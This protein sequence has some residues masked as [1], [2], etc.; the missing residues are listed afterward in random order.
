VCDGCNRPLKGRA[1][2]AGVPE[3]YERSDELIERIQELQRERA[4]LAVQ[5]VEHGSINPE[6][7]LDYLSDLA[8]CGEAPATKA[9]DGGSS[10]SGGRYR[11]RNWTRT[12]DLCTSIANAGAL[13][14][15]RGNARDSFTHSPQRGSGQL[16]HVDLPSSQRRL[17]DPQSSHRCKL[18]DEHALAA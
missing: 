17:P 8:V 15:E 3:Q 1:R 10:A 2:R 5:P 14:S 12:S 13:C 7:A 16:G 4:E 6:E 11:G 9:A 18:S